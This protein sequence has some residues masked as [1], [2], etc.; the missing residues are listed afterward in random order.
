MQKKK[1]G[2]TDLLISPVGFGSWAIGGGDWAYAWGQQDD[3]DALDAILKAVE[4]GINWIDTAAVY[5][6]G[7]S[8]ELVGK[9]LTGMKHRPYIFTKCSLVWDGSRQVSSCLKAGS[10]RREC[11][12]S[13]KRLCVDAID[14]YQVHWPNPEEDIE[15]GWEEMVRMREEGLVRHI[16][17]SNFNVDQLR[18]V[19]AIEPPASLQP[20]YSMLRPA[21]EKEILPFCRENNIGVIVYSPML[22]GMLSGSMSRERAA[23]FPLDDWRRKNKEF[24]EPRLSA[25][26]ELAELLKRIGMPLGRSAGEVAIAWT[27]RHPAVTGAI[28][29]GRNARQVEGTAGA[30]DLKLEDADL[31]AIARFIGGMPK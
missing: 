10:V 31:D 16:G 26:L 21:I 12:A 23:A 7:H 29:G 28:A 9:A 17:V 6:L 11:E 8:E 20:P 4:L 13:L 3:G 5:G 27:L 2:N 18:R 24:Q 15:E 14:L 19:M 30:M 25:N 1:L 22:S